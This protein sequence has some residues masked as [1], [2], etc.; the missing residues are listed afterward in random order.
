MSYYPVFSRKWPI[1]MLI[2]NLCTHWRYTCTKEHCIFKKY[3]DN[4]TQYGVKEKTI[5]WW[6][7]HHITHYEVRIS[8]LMMMFVDVGNWQLV[9]FIH[10]GCMFI[11]SITKTFEECS[12]TKFDSNWA[13]A[14]LMELDC[15]CC[16]VIHIILIH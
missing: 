9:Q 4:I 12:I 16:L 5:P 8:C 3:V 15:L 11:T 10:K 7:F 2:F 6:C 14:G 1:L 13:Y